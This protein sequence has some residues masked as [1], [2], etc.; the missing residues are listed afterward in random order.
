MGVVAG[1]SR[2]GAGR[3]RFFAIK[4]E[5]M[6]EEGRRDWMNAYAFFKDVRV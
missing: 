6:L 5:N 1:D 4:P 3:G 2:D